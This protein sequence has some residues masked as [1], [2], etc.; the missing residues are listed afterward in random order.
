MILKNQNHLQ[1]SQVVL[2]VSC[3]Y[4]AGDGKSVPYGLFTQKNKSCGIY[5]SFI[6]YIILYAF[7]HRLC[8]PGI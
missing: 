6:V 8:V 4:Y 1:L 2:F 3:R 5:R 7:L